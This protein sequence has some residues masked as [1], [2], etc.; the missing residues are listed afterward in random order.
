VP[1][2]LPSNT[3][4]KMRTVS[5]FARWL[6]Y[7]DVP[8]PAL[9]V[10]PAS[11]PRREA[12]RGHPSTRNRARAVALPKLVT[13]KTRPNVCPHVLS[14]F[15]NPYVLTLF[16]LEHLRR[17]HGP[18]PDPRRSKE[19]S[20]AAHPQFPAKRTA[21][22]KGVQQRAFGISDFH[23]QMPSLRGAVAPRE[24]RRTESRPFGARG[25]PNFRLVP[26]LTRKSAHFRAPDI[27]GL[28]T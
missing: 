26:I 9:D 2:V 1:V 28:L 21:V 12:D 25:K 3:P 22:W 4:D 23:D 27:G 6:V 19:Y 13:V 16:A 11:P 24:D 5:G 14:P 17:P 15:S 18:C 8:A 10:L 20:A 7:C